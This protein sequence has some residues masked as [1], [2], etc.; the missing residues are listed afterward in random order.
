MPSKIGVG[1]L[2][3]ASDVL[4]VVSFILRISME[5][6]AAH[7]GLESDEETAE[8]RLK[9]VYTSYQILISVKVAF[10]FIQ[11]LTYL[12]IYRPLGV[13]VVTL[14]DMVADVANFSVLLGVT[15]CTFMVALALI[16]PTLTLTLTLSLTVTV[17]LTLTLTLT[18]TRWRSLGCSARAASSLS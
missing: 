8:R 18:L 6:I 2:A 16:T 10:I 4:V 15:I 1:Q 17:T 12:I 7:P 3:Y 14:G 5:V 11:T 9:N 13:L